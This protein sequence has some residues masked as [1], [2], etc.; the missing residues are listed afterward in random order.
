MNIFLNIIT[1]IERV[2][3]II[4]CIIYWPIVFRN[5]IICILRTIAK[6]DYR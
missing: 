3:D 4:I 6:Q 2:F 5:L 1:T